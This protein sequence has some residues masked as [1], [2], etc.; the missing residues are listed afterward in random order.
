MTLVSKNV[1][2]NIKDGIVNA[3]MPIKARSKSSILM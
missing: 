1:Y 2:I 3:T